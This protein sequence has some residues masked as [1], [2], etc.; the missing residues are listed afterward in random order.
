[1]E[2]APDIGKQLRKFAGAESVDV[3]ANGVPCATINKFTFELKGASA[4]PVLRFSLDEYSATHSI[5]AIRS[6]SEERLSLAIRR[7]GS[8]HP[9]RLE[10]VRKE[11]KRASDD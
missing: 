10:F 2:L 1:M 9:G 3:C 6:C 8:S 11:Y 5:L 7:F 4:Q